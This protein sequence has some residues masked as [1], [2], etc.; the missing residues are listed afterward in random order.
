MDK[1]EYKVCLEEI[2]TLISEG[3]FGRAV[4]IAD[5]IDWKRVKSVNTLCQ[6]SDLYKVNH[7]FEESRDILLLA[8]DRYPTG[9]QIVSS[10]CDLELRLGEYVQALQYYNEFVQIAP[11]DPG[12]YILQYKIY[13]AQ[14]VS[15]PEQIAVL[16]KL[17]A[18]DYR[19]RWAYELALL[20]YRNG[21][22]TLCVSECDELLAFFGD[23]RFVENAKALKAEALGV[24]QPAPA[25]Q[26]PAQPEPAAEGAQD[27]AYADQN[28]DP[29]AGYA[30][31]NY[32]PNAGYA[33][34]NYDP[35]A[36]YADQ[37]Y[38]P[39]AGYAD[40]NYDPNAG[41]ADQNYDPNAGYADQNYDPNAAY[42][43][44]GYDQNAGYADQNF[45]PNA[46]YAGQGYD[47]NTGYADQNYDPNAGYADQG[48]AQNA[49][50]AAPYAAQQE[51][52]L[53]KV[54]DAS[55]NTQELRDLVASGLQDLEKQEERET[56]P[57]PVL[58]QDRPAPEAEEPAAPQLQESPAAAED[59]DADMKVVPAP[60]AHA[61]E[62]EAPA[63]PEAEA[64][65]AAAAQERPAL[66]EY[67]PQPAKKDLS[68]RYDTVLAQE[69]DGQYAMVMP[70]ARPAEKQIT[71]QMDL[72]GILNEWD[73]IKTDS[74]KR[75]SEQIR[76]RFLENTGPILQDFDEKS[77]DG[78]LEH[79]ERD[80]A[81]E[82]RLAA[83]ASVIP[84]GANLP[85]GFTPVERYKAVVARGD[86]MGSREEIKE[87]AYR[88]T[89]IKKDGA[90]RIWRP[91]DVEEAAEA[92]EAA[93]S[94]EADRPAY[95]EARRPE[96]AAPRHEVQEP[97]Y[98]EPQYEEQ[99]SEYTAPEYA[100]QEPAY[101]EPAYEA[102]EP[103]HAAPEYEA[104]EPEHAAPEYEAQEPEYAEPEYEAQEPEYAEPEYET[105][106][107]EYTEPEYEA[108]KK[109]APKYEAEEAQEPAYEEPAYEAGEPAEP[110]YE[111]QEAEPEA[112]EAPAEEAPEEAKEPEAEEAPVE[113]ERPH[114]RHALREDRIKA[115]RPQHRNPEG[116]RRERAQQEAAPAEDAQEARHGAPEGARAGRRGLGIARRSQEKAAVRKLTEEEQKLFGQYMTSA[117]TRRQIVRAIDDISLAAC[118]GNVVLTG[119]SGTDTAGLAKALI[120]EIRAIDSNFS[121]KVARSSGPVINRKDLAKALT[122]IEN[123][124][125]IIEQA[126]SLSEE[127]CMRLHRELEREERG[128]IVILIDTAKAMDRFMRHNEASLGRNFNVRIDITALDNDALVEVAKNYAKEKNYSIDEFGILALHTRISSLQTID[129]T[130]TVDEVKGIVDEAIGYAEKKTPGHL[131]DVIFRKR[132]DEDDMVIL[133][134]KDFQHY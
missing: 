117:E 15:L 10:L 68:H 81:R 80:I 78:V 31:Q 61:P 27:A 85:D 32:D 75:R 91:K 93:R 82:E 53:P 114:R 36:G 50:A 17:K 35:N 19:D 1:Y 49:Y 110:E 83:A 133:R 76:R 66:R 16:Q 52:D 88:D 51:D 101:E 22:K 98:A 33:D 4:E 57:Q 119:Q 30:D 100:A 124:A 58:T 8:Y 102:Q 2:D 77:K 122:Q 34:Q 105:Q 129:H 97:A 40:Q 84:E 116:H 20:Y 95:A 70:E 69:T 29:N 131:M 103:E 111:A 42:A 54:P 21:D 62:A 125:L 14:S 118:T 59:E 65:Q 106:E 73:R 24:E 79:L 55:F 109:Q 6:I 86:E 112:E 60:E 120:R 18:A 108:P 38:D 47:P 127:S 28:Y 7:R 41:Y 72:E 13:K 11:R 44:Q 132:Y 89:L 5:T 45:D 37:N 56:A 39:N 48:Y 107:P 3:D 90:T 126:S 128:M 104:Q 94:R 92:A 87:P 43:G 121:G 26:A 25:P 9:R 130:V 74:E 113:P 99:E 96:H 134:E 115:Q 23:G 46:A 71:G 123:G 64:P 67:T 12:R 63:Q